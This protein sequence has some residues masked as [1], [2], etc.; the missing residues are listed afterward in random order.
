MRKAILVASIALIITFVFLQ[1]LYRFIFPNTYLSSVKISGKSTH[2]I[3]ELLIK[4]ETKP[5]ELQVK[6]RLYKFTFKQI[7]II[8]DKPTTLRVLF[9]RNNRF[10]ENIKLWLDA[11][12]NKKTILPTLIFTQDY[13]DFMKNTVFDFSAETN[14]YIIDDIGKQII[15]QENANKYQMDAE[16]TKYLI[17]YNFGN[18]KTINPD[19]IEPINYEKINV[20]RQNTRLKNIFNEPIIITTGDNGNRYSFSIGTE[21]LKSIMAINY[22]PDND[23]LE[24]DVNENNLAEFVQKNN[25]LIVLDTD[26]KISF[27]D[28]KN[29]LMNLINSRLQGNNSNTIIAKTENTSNTDGTKAPKYIEIDISQQTMYLFANN[30]LVNKFKISSGLYKPTPR[31]E[32]KIINKAF[33]AYSDLYN[34][35][36]PYWMAFYYE[37]DTNSYYGIHELPYW[38]SGSGQKIQRPREFIGSPHTGGC[39]ALDI[40]SSKEVYNFSEIGMPVY[41]YN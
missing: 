26:K 27:Y 38:V 14:K 37:T 36:M 11:I 19:L 5:L 29:D 40:G 3:N 24:V 31:G 6:N 30:E 21:I 10:P 7:G 13:Y 9:E 4:I 12:S 20:E 32:Y 33:N 16:K 35:W 25:N 18:G 41:I 22:K 23:K 34:V 15:Y 17:V 1:Y 2:T 28:L 39:V 8:L